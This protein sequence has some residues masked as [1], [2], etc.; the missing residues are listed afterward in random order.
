MRALSIITVFAFSIICM[1]TSGHATT[2]DHHEFEAWLEAPFVAGKDGTRALT[3]H[4][5]A[6]DARPGHT[7]HWRLD[8]L[9]PNGRA[10]RMW[11]RTQPLEEPGRNVTI[12][13]HAP[14]T[15]RQGVY[16]L[17]LR[18]RAGNNPEVEQ[19]WNVAVGALPA[20]PAASL[21]ATDAVE[22]L[23]Y[24]IYLGN[25]HSQTNHSDGGGALDHCTGAQAPQSAALGPADAYAY[26]R[27]HGL[28]FLMTS[29]HNH[30]YDGSD[31]TNIEADPAAATALY[32]SGLQA[33]AQWNRTHSGFLAIYGQE[34]GV[35]SHGG[36]L[37]ILNS[38]ELLGWERNALGELLADTESPRNDYAALYRLM[39]ERGWAGQF[40][41][42]QRHQFAI[43]GKP[44][45]W[46]EDGDQA[47]LLCEVMNSNAFSAHTDEAEPRLSTYEAACNQ[48]L[49]AGYHLAFSSDQDNHCANWGASYSNRT[50]VLVE[51][52]APLDAASLLAAL[53]ARRVFAT[54]DKNA[55]LILTANGHLMGERFVNRGKLTLRASYASLSGHRAA[56]IDIFHGVPGRNGAVAA[57]GGTARTV[58][59]PAAGEHFYYARVTQDDGKMLWS[60]PIW[61]SQQPR[62]RALRK[63]ELR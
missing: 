48:L 3:L 38:G 22:A 25:L 33:A 51:R 34:W 5:S 21:Q 13:W 36:H 31:G 59:T 1:P 57:L 15:L 30:M 43:G 63:I 55:R 39:R 2:V 20:A 60:A 11:R 41:H 44:L 18:A 45:A 28:D 10:L 58:V 27:Q 29:E 6:P 17:R 23:P 46:T 40:N 7:L 56:A 14:P 53:R 26:A 24:A 49:E 35:I 32:R 52:G 62:N 19:D 37:N 4:F 50:G 8:L 47:M 42:P 54:M 16:R 9:A 12:R 61:V